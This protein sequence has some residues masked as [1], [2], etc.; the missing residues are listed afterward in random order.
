MIT[1]EIITELYHGEGMTMKEVAAEVNSSAPTIHRRMEE[2]GIKARNS[3]NPGD[4]FPDNDETAAVPPSMTMNAGY[5]YFVDS[6]E[7]PQIRIAHHRILAFVENSLEEVAQNHV[8]HKN[9]VKWDNR[10]ENLEVMSPSEHMSY[11]AT[12]QFN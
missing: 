2:Y 1:K 9:E 8:H 7:D 10:L 11:H 3:E 4:R 5:E 12:K 6:T